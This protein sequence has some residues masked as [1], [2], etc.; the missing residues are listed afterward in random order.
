MNDSAVD[1]ARNLSSGLIDSAI[2]K[3]HLRTTRKITPHVKRK[4]PNVTEQQIKAVNK[5][6]PKDSYS[7]EPSRYYYPVFANHHHAFQMDLLEQSHHGAA[8]RSSSKDRPPEFPAYFLILININTRY[9]HA[10]PTERKTKEAINEILST[11]ISTHPVTSI[12]CDDE[13]AFTSKIV[14]NTLTSHNVS[15]RIITE[16]RHSALSIVD[17]FIRTLRDMNTPTVKTQNQSTHPKYRDFSVK[18]MNK[19]LNIYNNTVHSATNHTPAE[20]EQDPN[21]ETQYI[22][23][24]LYQLERRRKQTNFELQ[25]DTYVRYILPKDPHTKSRFKV[26]PEAY[27]ISHRDGNAYVLIAQDGTVKT[28]SRWRIIPLG[29]SLPPKLKFG[30]S[31]GNN[32]GTVQEILN[33]NPRTHRYTVLFNMPDGSTY[34]DTIHESFLRG[35]TPQIQSQIEKEYHTRG[36]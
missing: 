32:N 6:R 30:S 17:R 13:S 31:F 23:E 26:S 8:E 21:L 7:H 27:R 25:P 3:T 10:I 24:K 15:L 14:L 12:V 19:L 5:T 36:L 1:S 18:R 28:V 9:A 33:Y 22:T 4:H 2:D 34:Q 20:M 35:S 16:Q 11:F 29:S